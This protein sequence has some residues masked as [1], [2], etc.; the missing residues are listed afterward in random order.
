MP[1]GVEP[2]EPMRQSKICRMSSS[3]E[4]GR[5]QLECRQDFTGSGICQTFAGKSRDQENVIPAERQP[6]RLDQPARDQAKTEEASKRQSS[7]VLS[8]NALAAVALKNAVSHKLTIAKAEG[9]DSDS[10]L[11]MSQL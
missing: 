10:D 6:T 3:P 4:R 11:D 2:S 5:A 1:A 8:K 7:K 9:W